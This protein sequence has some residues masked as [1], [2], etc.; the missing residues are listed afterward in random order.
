MQLKAWR[1][2]GLKKAALLSFL[3]FITASLFILF[4]AKER[5]KGTATDAPLERQGR[6]ETQPVK[7][8][9]EFLQSGSAILSD[10]FAARQGAETVVEKGEKEERR[11]ENNAPGKRSKFVL[12]G[13][14]ECGGDWIAIIASGGKS[15]LYREKERL[16]AYS[17]ESIALERVVLRRG[18]ETLALQVAR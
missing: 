5:A 4:G 2:K 11:V 1:G 3:V 7:R 12:T 17:V 16:G 15:G 8:P 6:L 18:P 9:D 13:V 10:P 14:M